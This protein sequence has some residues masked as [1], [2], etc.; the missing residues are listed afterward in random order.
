VRTALALLFVAPLALAAPVPKE[1]KK[2]RPTMDGTWE[3]VEYH[4]NGKKSDRT[5]F[6]RW[7]IAG[8]SLRIDRTDAAELAPPTYSL[9]KPDGGADD[10][11]DYVITYPNA[12]RQKRTNPGVFEVDGDTFKF[13]WTTSGE[14]PAECKPARGNVMY[15]FKRVEGDK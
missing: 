8:E 13:C 14:R 9:K 5:V 6:T 2:Q 15:V 1:V 7:V 11:L 3:V 4:T 12:A 10:A